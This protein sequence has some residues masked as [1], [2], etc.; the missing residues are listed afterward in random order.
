VEPIPP[1]PRPGRHR[2]LCRRGVA[3]RVQEW[4]SAPRAVVRPCRRRLGDQIGGLS[5]RPG[6]QEPQGWQID[7][8]PLVVPRDGPVLVRDVSLERS[9]V[10]PRDAGM[11]V[12]PVPPFG[13][14]LGL[15]P[16]PRGLLGRDLGGFPK[17]G[18]QNG[19]RP[20]GTVLQR[21]SVAIQPASQPFWESPPL[22]GHPPHEC[23]RPD[24]SHARIGDCTNGGPGRPQQQSFVRVLLPAVQLGLAAVAGPEIGPGVPVAD[25]PLVPVLGTGPRERDECGGSRPGKVRRQ[26]AVRI[27]PE[28]DAI[29]HPPPCPPGHCV[30]VIVGRGRGG[31]RSRWRRRGIMTTHTSGSRHWDRWKLLASRCSP[32]LWL[33]HHLMTNGEVSILNRQES[34]ITCNGIIELP[35]RQMIADLPLVKPSSR[36]LRVLGELLLRSTINRF[37][38]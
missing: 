16:V 5:D 4:W 26:P 7:G 19:P 38:F 9:D 18:L 22:V 15:D 37:F 11:D 24:R 17:V 12:G 13:A 30:V 20:C 2:G 8:S 27:V 31:R 23:A 3:P 36:A 29:D 14:V 10:P 34:S 6:P 28:G 32:R 25:L 1:P 21:R 33:S 35:P